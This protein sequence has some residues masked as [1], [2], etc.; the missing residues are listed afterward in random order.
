[1]DGITN[2]GID[3]FTQSNG[4]GSFVCVFI[5]EKMS[6]SAV[7]QVMWTSLGSLGWLQT[8]SNIP[9]SAS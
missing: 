1:M 6:H 2:L 7:A 9:V 8:N 3:Y 5:F 4:S